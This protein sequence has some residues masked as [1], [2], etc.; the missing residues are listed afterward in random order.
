[1]KKLHDVQTHFLGFVLNGM[2]NQDMGKY[3]YGYSTYYSKE[4]A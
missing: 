2:K 1:M 3:Y 4:K